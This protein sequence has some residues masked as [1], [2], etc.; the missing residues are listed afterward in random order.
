MSLNLIRKKFL[1]ATCLM[2]SSLFVIILSDTI[3]LK[4]A[5]PAPPCGSGCIR[6]TNAREND[7]NNGFPSLFPNLSLPAC[8]TGERTPEDGDLPVYNCI[9]W[10]VGITNSWKWEEVDEAGDDD[11][12][13][14]VSDFTQYYANY[15]LYP[16]DDCDS[17][18][19][20]VRL[21][22]KNGTPTHADRKVGG[23]FESKIGH[24]VRIRHG[25]SE[26]EGG[27]YGDICKCYGN[28]AT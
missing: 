23:S 6:C 16:W 15:G 19:V 25:S 18:V 12:V 5:P 24:E 10:S 7:V 4:A 21:Y 26:L 28:Y 22:C 20:T 8:V 9:A 27:E 17:S 3:E 2:V 14:E 1:F 13:M 11:G